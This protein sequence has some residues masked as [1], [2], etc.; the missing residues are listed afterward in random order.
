MHPRDKRLV[1]AVNLT[2]HAVF[3][4]KKG[5]QFRKTLID[6]RRIKV[7]NIPPCRKRFLALGTDRYGA[8]R[9]IAPYRIEILRERN[10]HLAA[11][12]IQG[13]RGVQPHGGQTARTL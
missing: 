11:D 4:G 7:P 13:A 12:R 5:I 6:N 3:V 8:H 10:R 1:E 9:S 2:I